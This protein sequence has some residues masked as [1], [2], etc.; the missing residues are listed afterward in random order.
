M[1]VKRMD[2]IRR[3]DGFFHKVNGVK[4]KAVYPKQGYVVMVV[5]EN[6]PID[7]DFEENIWVPSINDLKRIANLMDESDRLTFELLGHGWDGER[8][9][10]KLE[11]F[12]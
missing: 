7:Q 3:K 10:H 5:F 12:I 2:V 8:P 4:V 9:F 11:E 6:S 1:R